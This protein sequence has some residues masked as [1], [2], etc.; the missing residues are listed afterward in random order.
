MKIK[1][2]LLAACAALLSTSAS[3]G[4]VNVTFSGGNGSPLSITLPEVS[5]EITNDT[6]FNES[7]LFGIGIAVGQTP[8]HVFVGD[9]IGGNTADWSASGATTVTGTFSANF[10]SNNA[11]SGDNSGGIIW[12]GL[13]SSQNAVNGETVTYSG[14]TFG[15]DANVAEVFTSGE[16]EV[17]LLGGGHNT[18]VSTAGVAVPEPATYA[19]LFGI[20]A[21]GFVA[22]RRT[23]KSRGQ[24]QNIKI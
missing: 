12:L 10:L 11:L 4:I 21:L 13:L 1:Q 17:Y 15:N 19:G 20:A 8:A 7:N 14:G 16:Y 23:G 6:R 3:F 2:T 24:T 22:C 18:P 9:S 5:W